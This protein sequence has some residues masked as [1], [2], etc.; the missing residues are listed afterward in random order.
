MD[1]QILTC[2]H[3]GGISYLNSRYNY[4]SRCHYVFVKCDIC[5]AQGK[6]YT[7]ANDPVEDDWNNDS[8]QE[9]IRAW[10]MRTG[11]AAGTH[12]VE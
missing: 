2:P 4:R 6:T 5:G 8:C 1:Y 9:A 10:N 11:S 12:G 7:S 3:C